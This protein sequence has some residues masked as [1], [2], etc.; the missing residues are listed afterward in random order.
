LAA[1]YSSKQIQLGIDPYFCKGS[2]TTC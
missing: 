2:L 1:Y